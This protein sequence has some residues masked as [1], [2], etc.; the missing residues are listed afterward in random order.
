MKWEKI[1]VDSSTL[2][3][4]ILE[5]IEIK[6]FNIS[7]KK[8]GVIHLILWYMLW[9]LLIMESQSIYHPT[10]M[11]IPIANAIFDGKLDIEKFYNEKKEK[12]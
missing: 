10:S 9:L 3:N 11:I 12:K 2:V 1:T 5:L 6:L 7:S 8:L 4:K